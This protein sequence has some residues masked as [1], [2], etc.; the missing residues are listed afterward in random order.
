MQV[1]RM[2][3]AAALGLLLPGLALA[4]TE[5][6]D[7]QNQQGPRGGHPA[8]PANRPAP[9]VPQRPGAAP[10]ANRPSPGAPHH[11]APAAPS[12]P[13]PG[14][15]AA[16]PPLAG[17]QQS[18]RPPVAAQPLPPRGNQFWHQ[19]SYHARIHGPAFR[20]PAGWSYRSWVIG[21][22]L[23]ALFLAPAYIYAGW[24]A[25]GLMMPPPDYAW[26]RYGPDLLEVNLTT[27]E[28]VDVI[29]GVFY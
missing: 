27:G 1:N 21:G 11:P 8:A 16:R 13:P 14:S 26:V 12:H 28:I 20:Y 7:Y 22:R 9:G 5:Q 4:Q 25:L 29:Y 24:A 19:G 2:V 6:R 15:P 23:P 3:I 17:P 18:H 10:P